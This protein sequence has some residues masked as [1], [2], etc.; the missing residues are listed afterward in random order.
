MRVKFET[1]SLYLYAMSLTERALEINF[2]VNSDQLQI[3]M[4]EV[5]YK[6]M[7]PGIPS[8]EGVWQEIP[9]IAYYDDDADA[10]VIHVTLINSVNSY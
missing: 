1:W 10:S 2:I 6:R 5:K 3:H 8:A 4:D 9:F 7:S